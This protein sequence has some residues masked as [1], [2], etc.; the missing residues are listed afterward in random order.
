MKY[1]EARDRINTGDLVAVKSRQGFLPTLT[2]LV[3][4]PY[5]H[6]GIAIWIEGG[7][8]ISE[9]NSGGN[10]LVPLSQVDQPFSVLPSPVSTNGGLRGSLFYNL[11]SKVHYGFVG[12]IRIGL[13][14]LFGVVT[15]PWTEDPVCDEFSIKVYKDAGWLGVGLPPVVSPSGLVRA[16]GLPILEVEP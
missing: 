13:Y 9:I 11:R 16:L 8:Y 14:S 10:H 1:L 3:D 5:T 6:T 15:K 7:L 12:L 2:R 4:G